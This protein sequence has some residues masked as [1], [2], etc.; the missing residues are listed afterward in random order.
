MTNQQDTALLPVE[1]IARALELWFFRELS[2]EQRRSLFRLAYGDRYASEATMHSHQRLLLRR[3]L[4]DIAAEQAKPSASGEAGEVERVAQWL[5]DEGGFDEAW[6]NHTWPE[7]RDDTGQRD[8]G[9]VRLVPT[10]VQAKFRDVAR[11]LLLGRAAITA[12][13]ANAPEVKK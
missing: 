9:F 8:G 2:D 3:V 1:Q 5:H 7:H 10:D 12:L 6:S 11:R 13:R 4:R